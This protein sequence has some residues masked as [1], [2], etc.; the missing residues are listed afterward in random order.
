[1]TLKAQSHGL[2][3]SHGRRSDAVVAVVC[4]GRRLCS[5]FAAPLPSMRPLRR[6]RTSSLR[7]SVLRQ[8]LRSRMEEARLAKCSPLIAL[9]ANRSALPLPPIELMG[10]P[11]PSGY[12]F[13]ISGVPLSLYSSLYAAL[14]RSFLCDLRLPSIFICFLYAI[15]DYRT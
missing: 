7:S 15:P 3:C 11:A 1:M 13:F 10:I 8:R 9:W 4:P 2:G 5:K 12:P 6:T 14:P